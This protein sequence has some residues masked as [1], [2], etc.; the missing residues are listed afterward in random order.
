[1]NV[2]QVH[3]EDARNVIPHLV[4]L[5][6]TVRRL[7]QEIRE[8]IAVLVRDTARGVAQ[9][10]KERADVEVSFGYPATINAAIG[11][12]RTDLEPSMAD[13]WEGSRC[14][15]GASSN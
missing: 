15:S 14:I 13:L 2:T 4:T 11:A 10:H 1:V 12:C 3:G 6:G 5:R 7:A 9:T 8:Q